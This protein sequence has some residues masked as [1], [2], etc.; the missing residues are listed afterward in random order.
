MT[1]FTDT[2]SGIGAT[3]AAIANKVEIGTLTLSQS[4]KSIRRIWASAVTTTG[5]AADPLCGYVEVTSDDCLIAPF[6]IP[7]EPIGGV[8]GTASTFTAVNAPTKWD[9]NC[10]CPKGTVLTF[11]AVQDVNDMGV[12]PEILIT[13]EYS[14]DTAKGAQ[15][16]MKMGEPGVA[17]GT[18]TDTRTTMTE[19]S[20]T[21]CRRIIGFV[22]YAVSVTNAADEAVQG[23]F[24]FTSNDFAVAGPHKF[25]IN[26]SPTGD[27]T[28]AS[29]IIDGVTIWKGHVEVKNPPM[30][31]KVQPYYTNRDQLAAA[32]VT[33]AGIIY[34]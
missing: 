8:L 25:G 26:P 4:A 1:L 31:I 16:H 13:V 17:S 7:I 2:V 18:T 32:G 3:T 21:N 14:S 33:N 20:I 30:N 11:N 9:V 19:I 34:I 24:D 6:L 15:V 10:N 28:A 27:N 29:H 5:A 22:G 12:A 23:E